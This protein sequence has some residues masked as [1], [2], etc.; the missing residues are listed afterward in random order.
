MMHVKTSV[1]RSSVHGLG[2]FAEQDIGKGRVVYTANPKL[3]VVISEAE[4][5]L[6]QKEEREY[7]AHYGYLKAGKWHL[8]HDDI[9]F[10]NHSDN[11]NITASGNR[12]IAKQ[13]ISKGEEL[14]Q[15]YRDFE[16]LREELRTQ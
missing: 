4:F 11:P 1:Q 10:C 7:V 2:L 14:L 15:D 8:A 9:R 3:D 12:I 13:D 16:E 5:N 6:L